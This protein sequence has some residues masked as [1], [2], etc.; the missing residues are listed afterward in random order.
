MDFGQGPRPGRPPK[1]R[2][3]DVMRERVEAEI[4][5][6]IAP[7]FEAIEEAVVCATY[8][9][10]VIPSTV[11]DLG[12]RIQ[13]AE[14]LLDRVYGKPKQLTEIAGDPE[15]PVHLTHE[16]D[17]PDVRKALHGLVRR[18]GAAR[19]RGSGGARTGD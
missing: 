15:H 18:V 19:K 10:E 14:R 3:V 11:K 12:A 1:P 13:A 9:G 2:V 8:E 16:L 6:I 4:E 5:K 7:Y 17:D